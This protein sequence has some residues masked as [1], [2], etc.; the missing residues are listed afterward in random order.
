MFKFVWLSGLVFLLSGCAFLAIPPAVTIASYAADGIS[1]IFTG[2]SVTDHALS[3][4]AGEDCAMWRMIRLENPCRP[5]EDEAEIVLAEGREGR[6]ENPDVESQ[7]GTGAQI[8]AQAT[9]WTNP[10]DEPDEYLSVARLR[11]RAREDTAERLSRIA[12][13]ADGGT[14]PP[15]PSSQ[16]SDAGR[17]TAL[18]EI[19]P[20]PTPTKKPVA[21][22]VPP[23]P[24]TMFV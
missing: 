20:S 19:P 7:A 12:P 1:Y 14:T 4:L 3:S 2:K 6:E 11:P 13:A 22:I 10:Y 8:A 24:A 17:A 21:R 16:P 23:P 9:V 15:S 5:K 18:P